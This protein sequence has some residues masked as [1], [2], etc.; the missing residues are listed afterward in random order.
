MFQSSLGSWLV[1]ADS[2]STCS[3]VN[4]NQLQTCQRCRVWPG[5]R[6][7]TLSDRTFCRHCWTLAAPPA[8]P[9]PAL[10]QQQQQQQGV[11]C[12]MTS[13]SMLKRRS[14]LSLLISSRRAV[15]SCSAS[16]RSAVV[17]RGRPLSFTIMSPSLIPPLYWGRK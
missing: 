15:S 5:R 6:T 10:P 8:A 17:S 13:G 3:A 14:S 9:A 16:C 7:L 1:P 11:Y 12:M 2:V 4:N